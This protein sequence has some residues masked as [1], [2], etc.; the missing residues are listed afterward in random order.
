M[1]EFPITGWHDNV[2]PK[3]AVEIGRIISNPNVTK[4]KIGRTND[5]KRREF[6]SNEKVLTPTPTIDYIQKT[7]LKNNTQFLNPF[8]IFCIV[9][10][11]TIILNQEKGDTK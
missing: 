1:N 2:I 11:V 9:I 10:V 5:P 8:I 6:I 3:I 4:F 7:S